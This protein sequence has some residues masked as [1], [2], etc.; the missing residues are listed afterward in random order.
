MP[1][2]L[3]PLLGKPTIR[4]HKD[5]G[6]RAHHLL[7]GAEAKEGVRREGQ[8]KGVKA[9]QSSLQ[10]TILGK[11]EKE[12]LTKIQKAREV[13]VVREKVTLAFAVFVNKLKNPQSMTI[14][15]ARGQK[16]SLL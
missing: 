1:F 11:E 16:S 10:M 6:P 15:N 12:V 13:R 2:L 5:S 4:S 8:V 3:T 9:D 14:G 7:E